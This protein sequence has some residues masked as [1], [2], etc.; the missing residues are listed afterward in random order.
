[1]PADLSFAFYW[2]TLSQAKRPDP[3]HL[4]FA[5]WLSA[6]IRFTSSLKK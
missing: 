3:L 4:V 2:V 1:M 6:S 5:I